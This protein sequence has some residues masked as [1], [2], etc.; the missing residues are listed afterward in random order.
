MDIGTHMSNTLSYGQ[1]LVE[2][3]D[4]DAAALRLQGHE[5]VLERNTFGVWSAL[6]LAFRSVTLDFAFMLP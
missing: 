6:G 4:A 5:Q 2:H 1:G 3:T